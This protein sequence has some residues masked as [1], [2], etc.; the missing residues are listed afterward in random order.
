M[1]RWTIEKARQWRQGQPWRVGCNFIP[2]TAVNQLEMWQ[3]DSYDPS[4]IDRELDWAESLGFNALRVFLHDLVWRDDRDGFLG[5]MDDFLSRAH[6]HGMAVM[7][8]FFDDCHRPEPVAG[9]QPPPVRGVHNSGWVHSPGQR[10]V[11][12]VYDDSISPEDRARLKRYIQDVLRHFDRDERIWVWDLYNEP[13]QSGN[14]DRTLPLL[15]LV[16]EWALEIRPAQPLTACLD[17][18]VGEKN[19]ALNRDYSD[20]VTFHSYD[21]K[22]FDERVN[23]IEAEVGGRPVACT[24]YMAR[25]HG[26]TFEYC[27]PVFLQH[28]TD[29]FNWGLVA[30]KTQTHFNWKTVA[31]LERRR[32][33]GDFLRPGDPIP[34]PPIW[35]HDIFRPDGT[36]YDPNEVDFIRRFL[37]AARGTA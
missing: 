32:A 11:R 13:G 12:Q 5:R 16:W 14:G 29:A 17:G 27:L 22:H 26:T 24:E 37:R 20:M 31:D 19:I 4:T 25:E 33:E 9:P 8:V 1:S 21:K 15:R 23:S 28:R 3:A 34:E 7:P 30:G 6:R 35:H 18:A 10:L 36:P 2:S